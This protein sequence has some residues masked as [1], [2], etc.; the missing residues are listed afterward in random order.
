MHGFMCGFDNQI[1]AHAVQS[2]LSVT[3][4]DNT[5]VVYVAETTDRH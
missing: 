2:V 3:S 4:A 5:A 1:I